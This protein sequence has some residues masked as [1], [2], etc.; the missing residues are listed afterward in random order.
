[1]IDVRSSRWLEKRRMKDQEESDGCVGRGRKKGE[2]RDLK[3]REEREKKKRRENNL[4]YL[5]F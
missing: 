3:K 2:R 5:F 4:S 1:M